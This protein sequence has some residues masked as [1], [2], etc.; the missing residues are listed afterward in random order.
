M[1]QNHRRTPSKPSTR[2][3][4]NGRFAVSRLIIAMRRCA[5]AIF[6]VVVVSLTSGAVG[7]EPPLRLVGAPSLSPDGQTIVFDYAGDIWRVPAGGGRARPLTSHPADDSRPLYSPDGK[8]IAFTS[9]R[10]GEFAV[11]R[12]NSRGDGTRRLSFHSEGYRLQDWYPDGEHLLTTG[13]R[14]HHW[15]RPERLIRLSANQREKELVLADAYASDAS[16]S[17]D[18]RRV[19]FVRE[20]ERWWRKGYY[21][22]RSAQIWMLDL[23]TAAFRLVLSE[24]YDCRWPRWIGDENAF[25]FTRGDADGFDLHRFDFDDDAAE[26]A[27]DL[28]PE[29][30]LQPIPGSITRLT[31]FERDSVVFPMVSGDGSKVVFRHLFDVY[32]MPL[33]FDGDPPRPDKIKILPPIDFARDPQLRR[34]SGSAAE[35]AFSEDGLD[36]AMIVGGDLWVMDTVLREP[37]RVTDTAGFESSPVFSPDGDSIFL[38]RDLDGQVD[39][40]RVQRGDPERYW[41]QNERF[42][43]HSITDDSAVE[44]DLR[45]TPD[46]ESLVFVRGRGDLVRTTIEGKDRQTLVNGFSPPDYDISP[47][48]RWIAA[49]VT[50][51]DFNSD[52][53]I[54]D[55]D[56][57]SERYNLSRHPDDD[58]SPRFS[59]DGK[60]LAFTGR[61]VDREF[62]LHYVYLQAS[63][64][65]KSS[66]QRELDEAIELMKKK[67]KDAAKAKSTD[68][69]TATDDKSDQDGK[70]NKGG[71]PDDKDS[72]D[73][74]S[75]SDIEPIVIDFD[76][77]HQRIRTI[78]IPESYE[79]GLIWSPESDR[80]AFSATID[81]KSAMYTVAFPDEL[82]PKRYSSAS[83]TPL[84]WTK[85]AGGILFNIGGTPALVKGDTIERYSF[86]ADYSVDRHDRLTAG[87]DT[88]WRI[89]RDRWYDAKTGGRNWAA[90]KRKYREVAGDL[91]GPAALAELIQLMLGELNGSHN[92]YYPSGVDGYDSGQDWQQR[93]VHLGV[94]FD[95]AFQGPGL[96][97]RQVLPGG[98]ADKTGSRLNVGDVILSIDGVDVD[99]DMDLTKVLNGPRRRDIKLVVKSANA[100]DD[101]NDETDHDADNA[102]PADENTNDSGDAA[103]SDP[104]PV[105]DDA[106]DPRTVILRPISFSAARS[107]MYDAW[108]EHNRQTVIERSNG[109]LGYLHIRAMNMS[110]FYEFERQLYAAGYGRDGLVIDVREN[111]GGSTT[112]YLLTSLTQPRHAITVPRGG[113]P[114]YPQ[115]RMV[116]ATWHKPIIVLC[117]QNSFSNAEIFSHS[118]KSIGRGRLVGVPTAGGVIST[119]SVRVMDL[120]SMRM[121]FRAWFVAGTG[122]DMEMAGAVPDTI[123]W[124]VPGE[125]PAGVDRQLTTAIDQLVD[126]VE[127]LDPPPKRTYAT[128]RKPPPPTPAPLTPQSEETTK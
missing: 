74:K 10:D 47:D 99:P 65:D 79:R 81:G 106:E 118:I 43:T 49:A 113:G 7:A 12:T 24:T 4:A 108:L 115:S 39:I 21:G 52:V 51:D 41:W 95:D 6:V 9:N 124:P 101:A 32:T 94:R 120:G 127:S 103:K 34:S 111:G 38:T 98:P 19:L 117:N 114:G 126:E 85:K 42:E 17:S 102:D 26:L 16:I 100:D 59:P 36:I 80:L 15:R 73:K 60:L 8:S 40:V 125:L 90:V 93:T 66:R 67:R 119:G 112:D 1:P 5:T 57:P 76:R 53:L 25:V 56:D 78:R 18:G 63:E 64:R 107:L 70:D 20:G 29:Q 31:N 123:V 62:D 91:P 35:V 109:R 30:S 11:Y 122:T 55:F 88:A 96:K 3:A 71:K 92:G 48:G 13:S 105:K 22:P 69:K 23:E 77:L 46:G 27:A 72:A 68:G 28:T 116:Y 86:D 128:N 37:I 104:K 97:V 87:F 2:T 50:D 14:D 75:E 54:I 44:S 33:K 82:E 121:P 89:M 61:R 45:I 84:A 83:G 58:V 110:S